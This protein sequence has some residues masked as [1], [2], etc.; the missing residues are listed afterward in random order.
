MNVCSA[1][2][3]TLAA[4]RKHR[5]DLAGHQQGHGGFDSFAR[6]SGFQIYVPVKLIGNA[7]QKQLGIHRQASGNAHNKGSLRGG[8]FIWCHF[9][10]P[11]GGDL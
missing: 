11:R 7:F 2:P 3:L 1:Y 8:N 10:K 5:A 9:K 6:G 4:M